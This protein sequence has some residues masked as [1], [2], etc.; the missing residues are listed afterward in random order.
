MMVAPIQNPKTQ[1]APLIHHPSTVLDDLCRFT[2]A[3][4][5]WVAFDEQISLQLA[6]FEE[7]NRGHFTPQAVRKSLGR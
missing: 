5:S 2:M 4:P 1:P 6:A 7:Q 3:T